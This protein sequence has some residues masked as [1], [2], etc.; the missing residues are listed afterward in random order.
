MSSPWPKVRLKQWW[1]RG[2]ATRRVGIWKNVR[3]VAVKESQLR[4][5]RGCCITFI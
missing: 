4:A 2:K 3:S 5:Q 1:L